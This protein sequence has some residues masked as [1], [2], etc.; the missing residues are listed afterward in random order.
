MKRRARVPQCVGLPSEPGGHRAEATMTHRLT[1]SRL[2]L[3]RECLYP[4]RPDAVQDGECKTSASRLGSALHEA[5]QRHPEADLDA[6]AETWRL[7]AGESDTLCELYDSWAAWWP[8]Y[9]GDRIE[10]REVPFA[11]D[12]ETWTA[13]ELP[14]N[15][16]RDYSACKP[17]EI[18][19][20][21]DASLLSPFVSVEINLATGELEVLDLK[22][23][24][25]WISAKGHAQGAG[26]ALSVA[27]ALGYERVKF[28][29]ARVRPEGVETNSVV[30]HGAELDRIA[31]D[32][33]GYLQRIPTAVPVPGEHCASCP[34]AGNC[35]ETR[36][37]A[38][39]VRDVREDLRGLF[40]GELRSDGQADRLWTGLDQLEK[41]AT[42]QRAR[43]EVYAREHGGITRSS[44]KR[45][46]WVPQSRRRIKDEPAV[47]AVLDKR[48]GPEKATQLVKVKRTIPI[49]GVEKAAKE[50]APRGKKEEAA[51][52][53]MAELESTGHVAL[54]SYEG[55]RIT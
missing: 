42:E 39:A 25:D 14:S 21:V 54:T 2:G 30:L 3:A 55:W 13:R 49:G 51:A 26:L 9:V 31:L 7:T 23:G 24:F 8:G 47:I 33:E 34:A 41:F 32:I 45:A 48:L 16:H 37:L 5:A 46:E 19:G 53:I 43:L 11:W 28:T 38:V 18:P 35:P 12:T 10:R 50:G 6:I 4:F 36:A 1:A 22:T 20:T 15:G 17:S 29:I 44:G 52:E 27:R 40:L